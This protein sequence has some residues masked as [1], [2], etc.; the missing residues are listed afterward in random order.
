MQEANQAEIITF[1]RDV[2]KLE[3]GAIAQAMRLP[4]STVY[5]IYNRERERKKPKPEAKSAA[6]KRSCLKCG[7]AF[8]SF[9]PGNRLCSLHR[10]GSANPFEDE[11][12]VQL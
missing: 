2:E 7:R 5:D 8:N 6:K 4:R 3:F 1:L 12:V 9:G 11:A 10:P